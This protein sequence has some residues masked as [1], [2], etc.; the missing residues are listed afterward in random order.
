MATFS[1]L[2]LFTFVVN[3]LLYDDG[4]RFSVVTV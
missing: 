1:E 3:S 2:K 4:S